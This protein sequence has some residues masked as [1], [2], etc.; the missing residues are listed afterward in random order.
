MYWF[1]WHPAGHRKLVGAFSA[2]PRPPVESPRRVFA[3][4]VLGM[5]DPKNAKPRFG[6][7]SV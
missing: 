3:T 1:R 4:L 5:D 6:I 7:R 2:V